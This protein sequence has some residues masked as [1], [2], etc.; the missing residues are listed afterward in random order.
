M[1][2]FNH[3]DIT[4]ND[5]FILADEIGSGIKMYKLMLRCVQ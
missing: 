3:P 1:I 2:P 4:D 5:E